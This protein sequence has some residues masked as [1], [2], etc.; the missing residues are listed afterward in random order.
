MER[1]HG[2]ATGWALIAIGLM[3]ATLYVSSQQSAPAFDPGPYPPGR[4]DTN[5][6]VRQT[7]RMSC[8]PA[9]AATLLRAL[10]IAP[11]ANEHELAI[12]C[13]TDP[14]LG[15]R[16]PDLRAGL[17]EAAGQPA[18]MSRLTLKELRARTA[19]CILFVALDRQRAGSDALYRE[20]RDQCG[21]PEGEAHA[22]VFFGLVPG[23]SGEDVEVALIGDPRSGLERWGITH[24]KALWD[25]RLVAVR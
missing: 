6:I 2:K 19:P 3:G 16:D 12:L 22:V 1:R 4:T 21:W 24:F 14:Q 20:L 5:G 9:A 15:T 13:R 10:K 25:H 8:A 23:K 11:Q 7:T 17:E 18:D